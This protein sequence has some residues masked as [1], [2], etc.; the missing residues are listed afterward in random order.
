MSEGRKTK[1]NT[2]KPGNNVPSLVS[3]L[4]PLL[5]TL[6]AVPA[7]KKLLTGSVSLFTEQVVKGEFTAERQYIYKCK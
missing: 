1:R 7:C 6:N 3:L 5:I 2:L 4:C